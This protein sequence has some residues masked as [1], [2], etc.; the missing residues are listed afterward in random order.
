VT[1]AGIAALARL[2]RLRKLVVDG[3]P[4]VTRAA[5]AACAP[6]VDVTLA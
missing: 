6:A 4:A 3:S 5:F 2:P 1:D